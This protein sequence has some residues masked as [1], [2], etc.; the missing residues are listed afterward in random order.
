MEEKH[1]HCKKCG[2]SMSASSDRDLCDKCWENREIHVY[3]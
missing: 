3:D 2:E 1:K